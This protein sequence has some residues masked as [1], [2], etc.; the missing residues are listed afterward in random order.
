MHF[1]KWA[2]VFVVDDF[3]PVFYSGFKMSLFSLTLYSPFTQL[4]VTG[5]KRNMGEI[6]GLKMMVKSGLE[7]NIFEIP[8]CPKFAS[9]VY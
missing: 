8:P 2:D 3:F 6:S 5:S 7:Y 1:F 9:E 4:S